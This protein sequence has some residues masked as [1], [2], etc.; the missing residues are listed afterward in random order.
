MGSFSK[1]F[2]DMT[3]GELRDLHNSYVNVVD[4]LTKS[5]EDKNGKRI[6]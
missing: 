4:D 6:R 5:K 3:I 1:A 2:E